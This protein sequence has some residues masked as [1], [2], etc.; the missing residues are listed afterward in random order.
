MPTFFLNREMNFEQSE[1]PL[2]E[3]ASATEHPLFNSSIATPNLRCFMYSEGD[4][5][6]RWWKWRSN[7]DID[8]Y[9]E[10][11]TLDKT[12]TDLARLTKYSDPTWYAV[13]YVVNQLKEKLCNN[14]L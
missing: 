3:Q 7:V 5:P 8:V 2:F 10:W 14:L 4:T 1:N 6:K 11:I 13:N 12:C 9:D